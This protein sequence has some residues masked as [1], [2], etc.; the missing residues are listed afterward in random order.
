MPSA[1]SLADPEICGG[2]WLVDDVRKHQP[3][4]M[5]S[6]TQ[7]WVQALL[8]LAMLLVGEQKPMEPTITSYLKC[9]LNNGIRMQLLFKY[10]ATTMLRRA[11]LRLTN[12]VWNPSV[13][14]LVNCGLTRADGVGEER[15]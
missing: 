5:G 11:L 7:Q 15:A 2:E 14:A 3:M 10:Y 12:V 6:G 1:S 4:G 9:N 8:P 13:N